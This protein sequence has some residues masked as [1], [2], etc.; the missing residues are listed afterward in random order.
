L[1]LQTTIPSQFVILKE[2]VPLQEAT[3]KNEE[4]GN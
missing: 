2:A 1:A 4:G 3:R